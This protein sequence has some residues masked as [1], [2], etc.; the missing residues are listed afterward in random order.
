[1][2]NC[3][4]VFVAGGVRGF[5]RVFQRKGSGQALGSR[6]LSA[7]REFWSH[8]RRV[9]SFNICTSSGDP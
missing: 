4:V 7:T 5:T 2:G 8:K 3:S 6:R 1:M 9:I